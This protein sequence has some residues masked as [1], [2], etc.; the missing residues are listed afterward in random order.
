MQ[1]IV[2]F[3][4][5]PEEYQSREAFRFICYPEI[6]GQCEKGRLVR[7]AYYE[8]NVTGPERLEV[9]RIKVLRLL[10]L[11]CLL[12]T[13]C[14]PSFAQPYRL[15]ATE[16]LERYAGAEPGEMRDDPRESLLRSYLRRIQGFLREF[17]KYSGSYFGRPPPR[18]RSEARALIAW[19]VELRGSLATATEQL[20]NRLKIC[21]FGRYKCHQ[22]NRRFLR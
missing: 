9:V 20:V 12:T 2:E 14:L 22:K 19:L 1:W 10:C 5:S 7:H 16:R 15:V 17:F 8:R 11:A 4:G 13:S 18:V 21:L 6:C 3:E